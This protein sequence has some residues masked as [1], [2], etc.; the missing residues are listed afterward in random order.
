MNVSA[1][2]IIGS[3]LR[4]PPGRGRLDIEKQQRIFLLVFGFARFSDSS[5]D[6]SDSLPL[7][8]VSRVFNGEFDSGSGRTL[9]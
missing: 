5:L 6:S 4:V 7:R 3:N 2:I 9:A 8:S 1:N